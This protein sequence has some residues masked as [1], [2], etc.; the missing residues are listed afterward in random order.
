MVAVTSHTSPYA[1]N[2]CC[3]VVVVTKETMFLVFSIVAYGYALTLHCAPSQICLKIIYQMY[4]D[5]ARKK[6]KQV[7]HVFIS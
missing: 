6:L 2:L 1:T 3:K 7:Q 5:K 4:C